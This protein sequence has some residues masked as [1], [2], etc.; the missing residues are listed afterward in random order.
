MRK[1]KPYYE[2][3]RELPGYALHPDDQRHV[4]AAYVHR[5]TGEHTPAWV[6]Q[7]GEGN[8]KP[9]FRDDKEWLI[10]TVFTVN[11]NGRLDK[12]AKYCRSTPTWPF[13]K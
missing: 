8:Y 3:G 6:G 7:A 4:L 13:G 2:K 1:Q 9:Q 10:N 12:R 5:F 11:K